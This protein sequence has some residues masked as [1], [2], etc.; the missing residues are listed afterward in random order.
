MSESSNFTSF[1]EN[2]LL[3]VNNKLQKNNKDNC[4]TLFRYVKIDE[5]I[6]PCEDIKKEKKKDIHTP[7][8]NNLLEID[9]KIK[10][11]LFNSNNIMKEKIKTKNEYLKLLEQPH[12]FNQHIYYEKK[13][14]NI[15]QEI[16]KLKNLDKYKEY[17]NKTK[18]LLE[19]Y[20]DIVKN[21]NHKYNL[22]ENIDIEIE[23][24]D[25]NYIK[26]IMITN[27]FLD[28]ANKYVTNIKIQD[29]D[30]Y[31]LDFCKNCGNEL[32]DGGEYYYCEICEIITQKAID[33]IFIKESKGYESKINFINALNKLQGKGCN[34]PDSVYKKLDE[35]CSEINFPTSEII[36]KLPL[37]KNGTKRDTS[38]GLLENYLKACKLDSHLK[39]VIY[40]AHN[41][42]GWTIYNLNDYED[43]IIND[44][45]ELQHIYENL[46]TD[47]E[48][49][50][51][52][53][54]YTLYR[55][56]SKNYENC[57]V[58][59]FKILKNVTNIELKTEE[60]Y[61]ILGWKFVA[62]DI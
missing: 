26:R 1:A 8:S 25:E 58:S 11:K 53:V 17:V 57:D 23:E 56:V 10:E 59:H 18:N 46:K 6:I 14:K 3:N 9:K 37:L 29:G 27:E 30:S 45:I 43:K 60:A 34:V 32:T 31:P 61:R 2:F 7:I 4:F 49:S 48:S 50:S 41:Y 51:P 47:E 39:D 42:W 13:Y 62:L 55:V 40:I 38:Y 33:N 44:Y 15:C 24:E 16:E 19:N 52:N 28:I 54:Q 21:I 35:H 12:T 22:T 36:K 20:K 5:E